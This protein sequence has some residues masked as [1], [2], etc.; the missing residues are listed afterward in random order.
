MVGVKRV[1]N[2]LQQFSFFL[3][4]IAKLDKWYYGILL[5]KAFIDTANTILNI[6]IP[7]LLIDVIRNQ[8][9]WHYLLNLCIIVILIKILLILIS[10]RLE[11]YYEVRK[12]ILNQ[13]F[14]LE[15]AKKVM[16]LE[17]EKLESSEILDL[18]ERAE[19]PIARFGAVD[20]ILNSIIQ[21]LTTILSFSSIFLLLAKF[22]MIYAFGILILSLISVF[23]NKNFMKFMTKITNELMPI[24]R[25]Y[26]YYSNIA[27]MPDYQKEFRVYKLNLL[28][29]RKIQ[30]Y[31]DHICQWLHNVYTTQSKMQKKQVFI[32]GITRL[33]SYIFATY[34]VLT[35]DFNKRISIGEFVLIIN[36]TEN[37]SEII[38]KMFR[39][40]LDIYQTLG[41][42]NPF[43]EFMHIKTVLGVGD[44]VAEP[45]KRL[46]F[47][48]VSFRYPNSDKYALK[49]VNFVI[50]AGERIVFVGQNGAG[51]S[52]IIKLICLLYET[53]DGMILWNGRD[54]KE[55][56]KESILSQIGVI[57]QDY[58][59]FPFTI[60]ENIVNGNRDN[61]DDISI[62]Q[63]LNKV[64]LY[65]KI[66]ELPDG[67]QT[68]LDKSICDNATNLS[69]GQEQK[70]AIAR[71]VLQ[72]GSLML[73]DEPT[74][75][76]DPLAESEIYEQYLEY[77][78]NKISVWVS[79]RMSICNKASR[80]IVINNGEIVEIGTHMQLLE[81]NK[82]YREMYQTQEKHY[83]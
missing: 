2:I 65:E 36:A 22:N 19:Y 62:Y 53:Y 33:I 24:N 52:S 69:I 18:K 63:V 6:Y 60:K 74:S 34:R 17:Y 41:Y 68:Y 35:N 64:K 26:S 70:I 79:H 32:L 40:F 76:L 72:N 57:F 51:K 71:A 31:S 10:K 58:K 28:M 78:N 38:K 67:L 48:N 66:V 83:I 59:L 46:E 15:L 42:L 16:Q 61:I 56:K 55:Y 8:Y 27:T 47:R 12:D 73:F 82:L 44:I 43:Y 49:N 9:S 5:A 50:N 25:R 14:N 29:K 54:V 1:K 80:I 75:A 23:Y 13:G 3:V 45:L 77:S 81:S 20:M 4:F 37:L 11:G 30:E 7:T 21:L 39:A